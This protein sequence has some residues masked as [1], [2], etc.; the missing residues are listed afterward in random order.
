[1][2]Y[3]KK[4]TIPANTPKENSI[5]TTFSIKE[6]VI[7]RVEVYFPPGHACLTGVAFFYGNLQIFPY[8]EYDWIRGHDQ[9]VSG[10]LYYELPKVPADIT[11]KAFNEDVSYSHT[12]Y[13]RIEALK[14]EIALSVEYISKL[15]LIFEK[16]Y[17]IWK[18]PVKVIKE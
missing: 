15:Y 10:Y 17:N 9:V 2:L 12:V 3:C 7:T 8:H 5:S 18:Q 14:K 16:L 13:I 6:D 1:M 11:V 4:L